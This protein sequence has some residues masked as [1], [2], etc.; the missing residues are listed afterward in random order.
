MSISA[1]TMPRAKISVIQPQLRLVHHESEDTTTN[2][3]EQ[4]N[5]KPQ[6]VLVLGHGNY[7]C[8]STGCTYS[9]LP[10][11]A[12]YLIAARRETTCQLPVAS[13]PVGEIFSRRLSYKSK[14]AV[15]VSVAACARYPELARYLAQELCLLVA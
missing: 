12:Y 15:P 3:A 2:A 8:L 6:S 1:S 7:R 9:D 13:R 11:C 14:L 10:L 5:L 4:V